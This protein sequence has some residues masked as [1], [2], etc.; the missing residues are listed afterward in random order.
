MTIKEQAGHILYDCGLLEELSR[1]GTPHMIGSY[2]MDM[3]AW[4]DLDIDIEN[5]NMSLDKV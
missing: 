3:M 1:Y 5:E 4:N 2:R